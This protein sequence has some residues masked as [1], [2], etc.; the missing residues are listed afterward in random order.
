MSNS[1]Q[2]I[3]GFEK[4]LGLKTNFSTIPDLIIC[5][6]DGCGKKYKQW[7]WYEKHLS[8]HRNEDG[9]EPNDKSEHNKKFKCPKC[10][11]MCLHSPTI[12]RHYA[13]A[14][15]TWWKTKKLGRKKN[16]SQLLLL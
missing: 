2:K 15:E 7:I 5:E 9:V 13:S 3:R 16:N 14:H 6:V 11:Y 1:Y 8:M 4:K 12:R 10:N